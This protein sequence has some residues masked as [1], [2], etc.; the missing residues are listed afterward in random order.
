M[1]LFYQ[2][3]SVSMARLFRMMHRENLVGAAL[4][5]IS[6]KQEIPFSQNSTILSDPLASDLD[7]SYIENRTDVRKLSSICSA[8]PQL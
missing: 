6:H 3:K 7:R 8:A 2:W 5:R 1:F 4:Q